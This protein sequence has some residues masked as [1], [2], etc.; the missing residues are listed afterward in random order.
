MLLTNQR[1]L[2]LPGSRPPKIRLPRGITA[3]WPLDAAN[4][5]FSLAGAQVKPRDL[6]GNNF[7]VDAKSMGAAGRPPFNNDGIGYNFNATTNTCLVTS[8]DPL[9]GTTG[10]GINTT[11]LL[12]VYYYSYTTSD[13]GSGH[14]LL[15]FGSELKV[16]AEDG[17]SGTGLSTGAIYGETV[18]GARGTTAAAVSLNNWAHIGVTFVSGVV[19]TICINGVA[20]ATSVA[21]P[22]FSSSANAGNIGCRDA[23]A[24][25]FDGKIAHFMVCNGTIL[26]ASEIADVYYSTFVPDEVMPAM[27]TAAA[28]TFLAA[29]AQQNNLPVLGT[30]VY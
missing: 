27:F 26:T 20:V 9:Q 21:N 17:I 16:F 22:G 24:R 7:G 11:V 15:T 6:I 19:T 18:A 29:W 4:C 28:A 1:G 8:S 13:P 10:A 3:Y 2:I 25:I 5:E 23:A 30:G 12:W 14:R